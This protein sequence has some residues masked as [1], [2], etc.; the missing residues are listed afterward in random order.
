MRKVWVLLIG[1]TLLSLT[2]GLIGC[3]SDGDDLGSVTQLS[4]STQQQGIWVNGQG[5]VTVEPDIAT[6]RL[7]IES[8]A[9]TV[10]E[11]QSQAAVAMNNVMDSLDDNGIADRDIQTQY[12]SI[13]RETQWDWDKEE[14]VFV[15]YRVSNMVIVK[16][17]NIEK[18]SIIIDNAAQAGGDFIRIDS[19]NFSV[20]DPTEY[21]EEAREAAIADAKAKAEQLAKLAGVTLGK[22]TYISE[23]MLSTPP[24][25]MSGRAFADGAPEAAFITPITPGELEINLNLQ[26]AYAIKS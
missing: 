13:H 16:I 22:P 24:I 4:L 26:V 2:A 21:Y 9:S 3:N 10:S 25:P 20:D 1:I 18:I 5:T 23:N 6:L 17:R 12:F 15:G 14:E 11:A 8:E 7:G 19:I